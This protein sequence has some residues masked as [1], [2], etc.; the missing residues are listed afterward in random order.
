MN[1]KESEGATKVKSEQGSVTIGIDLGDR[2]SHYC[3]LNGD[4]KVIETGRIKTSREAFAAHFQDRPAAR[5]AVEV[6][7]HSAWVSRLLEESGHEVLVANA[8]EIPTISHSNKKNDNG[9]AEK[10]ARYARYDPKLL[11]PIKHRSQSAQLDLAV[12]RVRER[13][14]AARTMLINATRGIVKSSGYRLRSCSSRLPSR[15]APRCPRY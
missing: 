7:T 3:I 8:R 10:L 1:T 12:I 15:A 11:S 6:G 13:L 2:F 14:L 9:D 4:G 5:I